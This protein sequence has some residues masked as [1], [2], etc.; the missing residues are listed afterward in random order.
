MSIVHGEKVDM[1]WSIGHKKNSASPG[2]MQQL[3]VI[4]SIPDNRS[5]E[6]PVA[7]EMMKTFALM[8]I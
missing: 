6:M 4:Q 7:Q 3:R 8:Q 2:T 5:G 1:I